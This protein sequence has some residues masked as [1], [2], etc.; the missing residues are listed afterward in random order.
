MPPRHWPAFAA[1]SAAMPAVRGPSVLAVVSYVVA[2]GIGLRRAPVQAAET[3][4][5]PA[6]RAGCTF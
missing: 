4:D 5:R 3:G 6:A 1:A 2:L